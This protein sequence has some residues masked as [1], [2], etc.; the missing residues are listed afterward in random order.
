[1][2]IFN[3]NVMG[4]WNYSR[5]KNAAKRRDTRF[6]I[7]WYSGRKWLKFCY[8]EEIDKSWYTS[9]GLMET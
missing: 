1:M 6:V 2:L 5:Y 9:D 3:E 8:N 4:Y 7:T